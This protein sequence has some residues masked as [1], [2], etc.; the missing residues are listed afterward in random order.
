MDENKFKDVMLEHSDNKL[1]EVLKNRKDYQ[2][3]ATE[4]AIKEALKRR[5]ILDMADLET[6]YPLA[7]EPVSPIII[8]AEKE[9]NESAK[10]DILYGALWCIGGIVATAAD[11][12]YIFWGAIL[13]GG[14]QLIKGLMHNR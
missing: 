13:F 4:A 12:G 6:K 9:N 7:G 10:K 11:I 2:F 5:L 1:I 14:F 8:A 3:D